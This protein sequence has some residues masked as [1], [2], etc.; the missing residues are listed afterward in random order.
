MGG[1]RAVER[2]QRFAVSAI[3]PQALRDRAR[4]TPFAQKILAVIAFVALN[5][6]LFVAPVDYAS[7][8]GLAYPGAFLL[9]LVANAAVVLPIPYIPIIA[10]ISETAGSPL[11]VVLAAA[12]GSALGESTAFAVGRVEADLFSGHRW[13]ARIAGF[14][15]HE[16]R[17]FLFLLVFAMPLNPFFDVGGFGAGALGVRYRTF[18]SAVLLGRIVRFATLALL[19]SWLIPLFAR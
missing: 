4:T 2:A 16:R 11:L 14:F 5:V 3:S 1:G 15:A 19:A 13:Y 6:A 8:G 17:A 18:F 7:L 10:H 9:T 12:F